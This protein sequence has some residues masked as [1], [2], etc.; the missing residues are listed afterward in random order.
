MATQHRILLGSE[1]FS[2]FL[3]G[4]LDRKICGRH[5]SDLMLETMFDWTAFDLDAYFERIGHAGP[6]PVT[7]ATLE[8]IAARHPAAIPFEN[9]DPYL[10]RAVALDPA[11]LQRK[12]VHGGRGGWC[13][14][15][16]LLLG[17]A[18]TAVGFRP[19]GLGARVLWNAAPGA[20]GPRSHMVLLLEI[21][22]RSFIVDAG[23]GGL[24]LTAPLR[25]ERDVEQQ[26]PHER[27]RLRAAEADFI[28][29]AEVQGTWKALYQFDLQPQR[30]A[31][32]EVSNWYLSTHPQSHFLKGVLA[33]R[34]EPGRRYA[35]RSHEFSTHVTGGT[36]ER[37][38]LSSGREL[39]SV[40]EDTFRIAVPAGADVDAALDVLTATGISQGR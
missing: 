14:E 7:L 16:N 27:F 15:H 1:D 36:S 18:L 11:S 30:L 35:L 39:R 26:T 21:Q 24:T 13:F 28:L 17:A 20:L 22:Q 37:R 40:L 10:R 9:L 19:L 8:A 6:A 4:L 31:D 2:P 25:L 34:T 33:A 5:E 38:V 12:M 32:Y 3:V 23:F 29:E